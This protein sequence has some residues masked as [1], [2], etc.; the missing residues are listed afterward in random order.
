M[1]LF[2]GW[3]IL[4][5]VYLLSKNSLEEQNSL[6]QMDRSIKATYYTEDAVECRRAASSLHVSK[7]CDSG[8][9]ISSICDDLKQNQILET[10]TLLNIST[11]C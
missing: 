7:D 3:F 5:L 6:K 11:H 1:M 9:V 8:V 4:R 10:T 2:F